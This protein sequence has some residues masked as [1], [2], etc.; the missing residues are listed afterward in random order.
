MS[1]APG[2]PKPLSAPSGGGERWRDWGLFHFRR[3]FKASRSQSPSRFTETG[4]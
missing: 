1:V 4:Q 3:G 2:R